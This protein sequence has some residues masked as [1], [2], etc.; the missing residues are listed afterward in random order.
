M[1]YS[2][3]LIDTRVEEVYLAEIPQVSFK[4]SLS[5][6]KMSEMQSLPCSPHC[7][8]SPYA[9]CLVRMFTF[10]FAFQIKLHILSGK[11][12]ASSRQ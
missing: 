4:F 12:S 1:C 2:V 3:K 9:D 6:V 7:E 11:K 10:Q 8:F 5:R